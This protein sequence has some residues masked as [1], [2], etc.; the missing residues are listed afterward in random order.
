[1]PLH[2]PSSIVFGRT[3][4]PGR[5]QQVGPSEAGRDHRSVLRVQPSQQKGRGRTA[6]PRARAAARRA[7]G[8]V[9]G[10]TLGGWRDPKI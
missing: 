2:A 4:G 10:K 5:E 7:V 3:I 9:L 6:E 8:P 1:M